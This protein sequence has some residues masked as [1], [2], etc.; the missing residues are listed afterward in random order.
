[1]VLSE[2]ELAKQWRKD[3]QHARMRQADRCALVLLE[4][5]PSSGILHFFPLSLTE[6]EALEHCETRL[7]KLFD[8]LLPK[9]R[10][11]KIKCSL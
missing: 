2:G 10:S 7:V 5:L 3:L 8:H 9:M 1:M 11:R 4:A 6:T